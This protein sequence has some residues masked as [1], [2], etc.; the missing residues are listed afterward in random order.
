MSTINAIIADDE[1]PLRAMLKRRLAEIWPELS[2]AGEAENG[3]RALELV[4]ELQPD[5][6]F[7]DIRMP[8]LSGMEVAQKITGPCC[9]VFVTAY[10]QYAVEAF[11][12]AAVDYLLK[13]VTSERLE[14]TICRLKERLDA[15]PSSQ[16]DLAGLLEKLVNKAPS[17]EKQ[18]PLKWI[19]ALK[20]ET[21]RLV[22]VE[23]VCYFQARDK[24]TA[25]VTSQGEF[26]I[27]KP[28]RELADELDPQSFWRIHRGTIVNVKCI[29]K[30]SRSITGRLALKLVDSRETLAVSR[31]YSHLFKQM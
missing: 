7:L 15:P 1:A 5:I 25:V 19:R 16:P 20:G 9:V 6:A 28:V 10:D 17:L 27:R 3:L 11:E 26:L 29:Q 31:T 23:D 18:G 2:I 24:Y 8:G 22:P 12:S 13:P 4:M 21:V 14:K 30:V